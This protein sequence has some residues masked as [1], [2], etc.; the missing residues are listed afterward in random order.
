[1]SVQKKIYLCLFVYLTFTISY[2]LYFNLFARFKGKHTSLLFLPGKSDS[3][4]LKA[5][6][7]SAIEFVDQLNRSWRTK[8]EEKEK[9]RGERERLLRDRVESGRKPVRPREK[10]FFSIYT[11]Q[12]QI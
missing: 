8:R 9:R 4:T 6:K 3:T 7:V 5:T 10:G 12:S 1:M 11:Q 2:V